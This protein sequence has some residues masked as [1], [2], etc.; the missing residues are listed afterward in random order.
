MFTKIPKVKYYKN[1]SF[2]GFQENKDLASKKLF[3]EYHQTSFAKAK[4]MTNYDVGF[5]QKIGP[6]SN[7]KYPVYDIKK[8]QEIESLIKN[9]INVEKALKSSK[10]T[11]KMALRHYSIH[12][13]VDEQKD[14]VTIIF[15]PITTS[16][17]RVSCGI[18][19]FDKIHLYNNGVKDFYLTR[20][21]F[22]KTMT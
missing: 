17:N 20:V 13:I 22:Q 6:K 18:Q 12:D 2:E 19:K 11:F 21:L 8:G 10:E 1:K 3:N 14:Q 7:L 15:L 9:S 16:S 4:F 5:Q